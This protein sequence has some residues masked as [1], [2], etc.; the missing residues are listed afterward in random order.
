MRS[1]FDHCE[2]I[3]LAHHQILNALELELCA[4]VL[5][6]EHFVALFQDH[7]FILCTLS[8][9]LDSAMKGFL[10]SGIRNDNTTNLL[11]CRCWQYQ[12]TVC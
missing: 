10:L 2:H 12:H 1:F 4:T 11:L 3:A 5:A 7:C 8:Y 9:G 6:V